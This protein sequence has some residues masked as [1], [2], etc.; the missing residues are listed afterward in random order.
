VGFAGGVIEV[1]WEPQFG[2]VPANATSTPHR[3]IGRYDEASPLLRT[4]LQLEPDHG[5]AFTTWAWSAATGWSSQKPGSCWVGRWSTIP[6]TSM[7][8][9]PLVSQP[10]GTGTPPPRG[11]LWRRRWCW[12]PATPLPGRPGPAG[13]R[14]GVLRRR[15][16]CAVQA[17]AAAI[18]GRGVGAKDQEPA[19][20]AG[21]PRDALQRAGDAAHGRGG[22]P[23]QRW[24]PTGRLRRRD[25]SSC[26]PRWWP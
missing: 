20:Q 18:A 15:G 22:L 3:E 1:N 4:R 23:D 17:G 8:R 14:G 13:D 11:L 10:C 12:S 2:Q 16:R 9:W 19:A 25:R 21:R 26:W 5:G 7:P 6:A 24:R